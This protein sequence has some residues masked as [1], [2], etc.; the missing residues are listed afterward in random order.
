[1]TKFAAYDKDAIFAVAPTR[2]AALAAARREVR[3]DEARF[4]TAPISDAL[5][6]EIDKNGWDG[7]R[8]AFAF[9]ERGYIVR[10]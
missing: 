8:E 6:A 9:D 3:D 4:D 7:H 10:A 1:M 5:A 2:E